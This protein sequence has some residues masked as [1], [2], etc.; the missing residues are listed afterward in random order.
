MSAPF[1]RSSSTKTRRHSQQ[2]AWSGVRPCYKAASA[3][4]F[5]VRRLRFRLNESSCLPSGAHTRCRLRLFWST[6]ERAPSHQL[7]HQLLSQLLYEAHAERGFEAA[8]P[9]HARAGHRLYMERCG[10]LQAT[11]SNAQGGDLAPARTRTCML[12]SWWPGAL[13]SAPCKGTRAPARDHHLVP[14][15]RVG[16]LCQEQLSRFGVP[17]PA[18]RVQRSDTLLQRDQRLR[19]PHA[20]S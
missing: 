2:A 14:G 11:N 9:D 10:G 20:T 19:K 1:E 6:G 16:A 7:G 15:F 12:S 5:E 8:D 17:L 13:C 3:S 18:G 4:G